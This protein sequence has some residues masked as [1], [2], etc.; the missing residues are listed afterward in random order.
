MNLQALV[1]EIGEDRLAV[2]YTE[3]PPAIL[4]WFRFKGRAGAVV[5]ELWYTHDKEMHALI[6]E[7]THAIP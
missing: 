3:L 4:E 6:L 2:P 7:A 1:I 5:I